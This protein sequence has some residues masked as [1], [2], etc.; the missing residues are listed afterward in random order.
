MIREGNR[1]GK[2]R[3][4]AAKVKKIGENQYEV[5]E[6]TVTLVREGPLVG[7]IMFRS[8]LYLSGKKVRIC[9]PAYLGLLFSIEKLFK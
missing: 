9:L 7:G 3:I 6:N 8:G 1:Y 2:G 4:D 5:G